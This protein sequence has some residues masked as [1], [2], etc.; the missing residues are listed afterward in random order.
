VQLRLECFGE[1]CSVL[2]SISANTL[3]SGRLMN[4]KAEQQEVDDEDDLRSGQVHGDGSERTA[5]H[6]EEV[7]FQS[8]VFAIQAF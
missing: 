8:T 7:F 5:R 2:I 4:D 6:D 1:F 3:R